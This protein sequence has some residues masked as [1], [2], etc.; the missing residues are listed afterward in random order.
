MRGERRVYHYGRQTDA[1]AARLLLAAGRLLG[2][3]DG[4]TGRSKVLSP[5]AFRINC[6]GVSGDP[7]VDGDDFMERGLCPFG[8]I[9]EKEGT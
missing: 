8:V 1:R 6:R 7:L 2:G 9:R 3:L 4:V 5:S